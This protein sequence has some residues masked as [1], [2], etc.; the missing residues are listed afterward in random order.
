M[1]RYYLQLFTVCLSF[2]FMEARAQKEEEVHGKFTYTIGDNDNITLREAKHKC[3]VLAKAE[4][5][6]E[7]F[8]ELVTVDVIDSNAETNGEPVSSFFYENTM[9]MAKGEWI[10]DTQKTKLEV[11]YNEGKLTFTAEVW[12]RA[13]EIVPPSTDIK[14]SILKEG[15]NGKEET[16]KFDNGEQVYIDL[17][18]PADGYV[19]I[20]LIEGENETSCLLPYKKDPTGRYPIKYGRKYEFFDKEKDLSATHYFLTTKQPVEY[21]QIVVIFSRNP[22]SK[23]IDK[24]KDR[25][26]PNSLSTREFQKWLLKCQRTDREMVVKKKWVEI[27]GVQSPTTESGTQN[28]IN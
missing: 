9:A 4:A 28:N 3:E 19:A 17:Y 26:H 24:V 25:R 16:M 5:V 21:N 27:R 20:Y 1:K 11:E 23:C 7:A 12:G 14:W 13:R 8:G 18:S 6:K 2:L 22:F 10:E 15:K